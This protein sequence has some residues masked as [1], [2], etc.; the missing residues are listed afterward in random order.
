M[1]V[2]VALLL[3][4]TLANFAF[5]GAAHDVG[6]DRAQIAQS[7]APLAL[8]DHRGSDR[9]SG[10]FHDHCTWCAVGAPLFT[11]QSAGAPVVTAWF[12]TPPISIRHYKARSQAR[13]QLDA[14]P[15][16]PPALS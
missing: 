3:Q 6:C 1:L 12:S 14:A 11:L 10:G 4:G 16:A 5:G 8:T 9:N 13:L 2:A 7:A 15:R